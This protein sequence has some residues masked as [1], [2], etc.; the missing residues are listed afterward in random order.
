[1]RI[2]NLMIPAGPDGSREEGGLTLYRDA[3]GLAQKMFIY[4]AAIRYMAAGRPTVIF[5]GEEYGT[6]SSRDWAAKG[7]QL[8]GIKAVIARS[9]ERIHRSNLVG[10]GVLP[11][12]FQGSDTWQSLRL[13][14]EEL[15]DVIPDPQLR[16]QSEAT[17]VIT[18]PDGSR[19]ERTLT[20]R[21]DTPIEVDYYKHGGILPFVLRQLLAA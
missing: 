13:D 10:M 1:V 21:I 19:E 2:K 16:P 7:T 12:Q 5:A 17:L 6:G 14:G 3:Q 11:L 4:D 20:L 15:V 18:R 9:F 8:L